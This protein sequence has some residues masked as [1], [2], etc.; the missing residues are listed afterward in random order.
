MVAPLTRKVL[1]SKFRPS[2]IA[3]NL[4]HSRTVKAKP[5]ARSMVKNKPTPTEGA[6]S[7]SIICIARFGLGA[8][9]FGGSESD[10]AKALN[11]GATSA[12]RSDLC[13]GRA[14]SSAA[15]L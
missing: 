15:H 11:T 3:D 10:P 5:P 6:I 2:A 8:G 4:M 14:G 9:G 13:A 1:G 7:I 12:A